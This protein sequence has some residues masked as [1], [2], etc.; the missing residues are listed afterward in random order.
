MLV[1]IPLIIIGLSVRASGGI[2]NPGNLFYNILETSTP[3]WFL[4]FLSVALFAAFMSS[5]D[6]S[7]FAISSQLGKY[8]FWIKSKEQPYQNQD[9]TVVR[10]TRVTVIIV[11]I[12]TLATSLYFSSFLLK[13]LQL[14]SLLTVISTVVL[15]SLIFKTTRNETFFG[16]LVALASFLYAAFSGLISEVPQSTLYPSAAVILYMLAHNFAMRFYNHMRKM[17]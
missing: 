1:V 9:E 11:T 8:G 2:D 10:N 13:V 6:S 4:P 5:L 14:V 3:K 7:L 15:F 17:A 12:L 16:V